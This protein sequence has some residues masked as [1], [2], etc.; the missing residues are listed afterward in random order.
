[1]KRVIRPDKDNA[2]HTYRYELT[3][4]DKR[5]SQQFLRDIKDYM[6]VNYQIHCDP[7]FD[8]GHAR[9][10]LDNIVY[11]GKHIDYGDIKTARG[12]DCDNL[13]YSHFPSFDICDISR[14]YDIYEFEDPDDRQA[15]LDTWF[16]CEDF[17]A[18]IERVKI[19]AKVDCDM[20]TQYLNDVDFMDNAFYTFIGSLS[21]SE[22]KFFS[23]VSFAKRPQGKCMLNSSRDS[24]EEL[25]GSPYTGKMFVSFRLPL[26]KDGRQWNYLA[27]KTAV[28]AKNYTEDEF[29]DIIISLMS[30]GY[31]NDLSK[32]VG[33]Y[34]LREYVES[35]FNSE[36]RFELKHL[37]VGSSGETYVLVHDL[38]TSLRIDIETKLGSPT[39]TDPDSQEF[40]DWMKQA[41]TTIRKR[42]MSRISKARRTGRI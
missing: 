40:R 22:Q 26:A 3:S 4:E 8:Y 41:Y 5:I 10:L 38:S 15:I 32:Q 30:K 34:W 21:T 7:E 2:K 42:I 39:N 9:V 35:R 20:L 13:V 27:A 28:P 6:L 31:E 17:Y 16:S 11:D 24:W 23:D 29:S 14:H 19:A 1:M 36:G 18:G 25:F 37:S 12:E 33:A